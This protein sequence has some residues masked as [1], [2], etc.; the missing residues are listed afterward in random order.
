MQFSHLLISF[1]SYL[2]NVSPEPEI[3][4]IQS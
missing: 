4:P 3:L 2:A 1:S